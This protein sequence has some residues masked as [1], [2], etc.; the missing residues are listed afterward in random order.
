MSMLTRL[1][2][3]VSKHDTAAG[4][5]PAGAKEPEA[6]ASAKHHAGEITEKQKHLQQFTIDAQPPE[7]LGT[8]DGSLCSFASF[9]L[10]RT[11]NRYV[12]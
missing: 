9:F 7:L 2:H 10:F 1:E 11:K 4:H 3:D 6:S 8:T 12:S 5:D